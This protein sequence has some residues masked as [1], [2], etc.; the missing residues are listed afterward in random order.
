MKSMTRKFNSC[1][2]LNRY[3]SGGTSGLKNIIQQGRQARRDAGMG[4]LG[5]NTKVGGFLSNIG[6]GIGQFFGNLFN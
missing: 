5:Q 1:E 2:G 6:S 4:F 3:Q